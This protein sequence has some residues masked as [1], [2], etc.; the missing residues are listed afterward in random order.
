MALIRLFDQ[1]NSRKS[2]YLNVIL[3][4]LFY[5]A[6]S[7]VLK[8]F[9]TREDFLVFEILDISIVRGVITQLQILICVYIV[10]KIN[11]AGYITAVILNIYSL[12][13]A[14]SFLI[15]FKSLGSLPGVISYIAVI[16]II[17]FIME[18]KNQLFHYL[19]HI[20]D[21]K[22]NLEASKQKLYDLA[23]YDPITKLA[24]LKLFIEV[25]KQSIQEIIEKKELLAVVYI[26]LDSFKTVNDTMG[27]SSGNEVLI[28]IA[29][30]L[31][32]K[33]DEHALLSRSGRDEFFVMLGGMKN[34]Q[35]I[36]EAMDHL[37]EAFQRPVEI[38]G[39]EFFITASMGISVYPYDGEDA[40]ILIKNADLSMFESKKNGK[41]KF[42]FC[43]SEMK[44]DVNRK[45]M[46]MNSLYRSLER[47][48]LFLHF[49]PQIDVRTNE[50]IGFEALLRWNHPELGL[51]SPGQFIPL[52]EQT[53]LIKPI[54]LWVFKSVCQ[55]CKKCNANHEKEIRLSI[56]LSMEQLREPNI[57]QQ[58][59]AIVVETDMNPKNI[60]LEIT[61]SVAFHK[62]FDMIGVLTELKKVGF[63]IAI[64]DFGKEYSSLN[65][66]RSFPI[67]L[68]KIDMDF[69]HG[70]S[71]GSSK[72]RAVVKTIIQLAKNLGVRVLAEGVETKEQYEFLKEEDCDEIQ[73]FYFY[74]GMLAEEAGKLMSNPKLLE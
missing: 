44:E 73:G 66:I 15:R 11:K 32:E 7:F 18:Y 21:Q 23:Y 58:L 43:T 53:G 67:D 24:N 12:F 1:E 50:I 27:Y 39:V 25:L 72:D 5:L 19:K 26:D 47:N 64:D 28:E 74:K 16:I 35:D 48:E 3:C 42:T 29:K 62:G 45:V 14:L 17:S 30:R 65:R 40:E 63:L 22:L 31:N 61:E 60:E 55:T 71:S 4:S 41:N 46:L 9:S 49:Q 37:L 36:N 56:N 13:I 57:V 54:G 2:K 70:I 20:E 10:L 6:L 51:V 59:S 68:I 69:I 52:A 34:L 8:T 38:K 33:I